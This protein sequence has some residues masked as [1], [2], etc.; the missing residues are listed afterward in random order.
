VHRAEG[1]ERGGGSFQDVASGGAENVIAGSRY[2]A[3][4]RS[5]LEQRDQQRAGEIQPMQTTMEGSGEFHI[6][7][8]TPE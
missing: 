1:A 3:N 2:D 4:D 8:G 7:I 5:T 6:K